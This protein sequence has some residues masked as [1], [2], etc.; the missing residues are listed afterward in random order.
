MSHGQ[1][2][3]T[4]VDVDLGLSRNQREEVT[5][6]IA[7]DRLFRVSIACGAFLA[8]AIAVPPFAADTGLPSPIKFVSIQDLSGIT[9]KQGGDTKLGMDLAVEEINKSG[10]LG[11]SKIEIS[12]RDSATNPAQGASLMSA[13]MGQESAIVFGSVSSNVAIAQAPIAQRA[14]QPL[15]FT[16]AGS[17]GILEAGNY[18]FRATP[19]QLYYQNLTVDWMKKNGIKSMGIITDTNNPTINELRAAY[20]DLAPKAGI[21]IVADEESTTSAADISTQLTKI[22]EA[23]P[24]AAFINLM[25]SR[26]AIAV[27]QLRQNGFTGRIVGMQ[28]M[29]GNI[30]AS[31]GELGEGVV[32]ATDFNPGQT[33]PGAV[34]FVAAYKAKHGGQVPGFY[35]AE[36][37]DAVLFAAHALK[38]ANS[39]EPEAVIK[40]LEAVGT[41]GFEGA[42]GLVK[43]S[44]RQ[45][46]GSGV[47]VEWRKGAEVLVR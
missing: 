26:N 36:G 5:M 3:H 45:Q 44:G 4:A 18:V 34:K 8:G 29:G 23:K 39:V 13:A 7:K 2:S 35:Q 6:T 32:W 30:L 21:R 15:I 31:L 12:Y 14:R 41:E 1:R 19:I 33:N 24:D 37:Y 10:L 20:K 17:K 25:S 16:Q 22:R 38:K 42:A 9:G 43:F 46:Q 11:S 47:V 40:A 27:S 28:G